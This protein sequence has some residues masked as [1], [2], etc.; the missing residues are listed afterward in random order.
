MFD[1]A[2]KRIWVAGHSGMVG[3]ALVQRLLRE[4]CEILTIG[5]KSLD[6][7]RQANVEAYLAATRPDAIIFA[8]AHVGGICANQTAPVPFLQDNLTM[9]ANVFAAAHASGVDRLVYLA[10]SCVYP[11]LATQPITEDA[12]LAGPLETTNQ[13]YAI[14]KIAGVKLAQAYRA[15]YGRSYV[16]AMPT[17]LYGPGDTFDPVSSHVLPALLHNVH[18]ARQS[19]QAE[20][21]VWGSGTPLRE[22]LYAPDCADALVTVLKS[23]CDDSPINIGSGE[24]ISIAALAERICT[25]VG[26]SGAITFDPTRPDGTPRKRLD[27]TRLKALGWR[28]TTPLDRGLRQTYRWY[29]DAVAGGLAA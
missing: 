25:T 16:A 26:Y 10:S 6:L 7:R 12:L 13:W 1:I 8:A 18:A 28:A 24:E 3:S 14:A 23:Y 27:T 15:Q 11:R 9:A 29:L 17:N 20:V 5:R 2:G 4:P 19:G 22:F 21:E